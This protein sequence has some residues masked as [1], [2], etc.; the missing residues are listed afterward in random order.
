M[1]AA[2]LI[3][4]WLIGSEHLVLG[5]LFKSLED[6]LEGTY[7]DKPE[8]YPDSEIASVP[9]NDLAS[10]LSKSEDSKAKLELSKL[11]KGHLSKENQR[12]TT[13][14]AN[15][16]TY[17]LK[18]SDDKFEALFAAPSP[19][20]T[21]L[22]R[23]WVQKRDSVYMLVGK[24]TLSKAVF[25][26]DGGSANE[27]GAEFSVPIRQL[28]S[29][30]MSMPV[31]PLGGASDLTAEVTHREDNHYERGYSVDSEVVWEIKYRRIKKSF[32]KRKGPF[33]LGKSTA[34][35]LKSAGR[36]EEKESE[37]I[38]EVSLEDEETAVLEEQEEDEDE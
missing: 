35:E 15:A 20:G 18:N 14:K 8:P 29:A 26:E 31:D 4:S 5:M 19:G 9:I 10:T 1:A 33:Q 3:P 17:T 27:S 32:W 7:P 28:A 22:A 23:N 16:T 25:S 38:L 30:A 6:P 34:W 11:L 12:G 21:S 13:V 2:S 24:S 36:G 37:E